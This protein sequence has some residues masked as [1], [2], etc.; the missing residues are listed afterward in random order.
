MKFQQKCEAWATEDHLE[1]E[2]PDDLTYPVS[3]ETKLKSLINIMKPKMGILDKI[4]IPF[5]ENELEK[6]PQQLFDSLNTSCKGEIPDGI[7]NYLSKELYSKDFNSMSE[8]EQAIIKV[9]SVY[10]MIQF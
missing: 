7:I 1:V 9:L 10:L 5:I 3:I 8:S 6:T 2:D 4:N